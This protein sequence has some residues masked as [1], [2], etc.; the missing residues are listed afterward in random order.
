MQDN[1]YVMEE[2]IITADAP[3][4]VATDDATSDEEEKQGLLGRLGAW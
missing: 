1:P 2:T 3:E 4:D